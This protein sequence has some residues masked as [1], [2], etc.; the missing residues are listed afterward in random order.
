MSG[1]SKRLSSI[2]VCP[3]SL[4]AIRTRASVFTQARLGK[5]TTAPSSLVAALSIPMAISSQNQRLKMT[6]LSALLLILQ[7]VGK[8]KK[9]SLLS[10]NTGDPNITRG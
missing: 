9:E 3:I 10:T 2:I 7:N 6:S 5:K 4:E 8:A 1:K